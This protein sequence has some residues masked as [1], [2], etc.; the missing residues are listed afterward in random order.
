MFHH[1]D[2][3]IYRNVKYKFMQPLLVVKRKIWKPTT[4]STSLVVTLPQVEFLKENDEVNLLVMPNRKI[5]IE[6][7]K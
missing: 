6:K 5:I 7:V 2:I 1:I 3:N 4:S